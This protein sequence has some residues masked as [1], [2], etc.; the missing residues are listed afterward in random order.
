[1]D[2]VITMLAASGGACAALLFALYYIG[3]RM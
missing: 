2:P 3:W 1:M